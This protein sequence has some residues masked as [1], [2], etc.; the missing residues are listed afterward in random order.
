M[1]VPNRYLIYWGDQPVKDLRTLTPA[2]FTIVRRHGVLLARSAKSLVLTA[3]I[4]CIISYEIHTFSLELAILSSL[5]ALVCAALAL[6][7]YSHSKRLFQVQPDDL[8]AVV[9]GQEVDGRGTVIIRNGKLTWFTKLLNVKQ[10]AAL[11]PASTEALA[12]IDGIP[13]GVTTR[14]M[15]PDET[16]EYRGGGPVI[17]E[18]V[19]FLILL[20]LLASLCIGSN[21]PEIYIAVIGGALIVSLARTL[22]QRQ[23]NRVSSPILTVRVNARIGRRT[24]RWAEFTPDGRPWTIEGEPAMW[25]RP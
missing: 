1:S 21:A 25:R 14:E 4:F 17:S 15:S 22:A 11:P 23:F 5:A 19:C 12:K 24:V 16:A 18:V 8:L 3:I 9:D 6:L 2:G 10:V 13:E 20:G 7:Y